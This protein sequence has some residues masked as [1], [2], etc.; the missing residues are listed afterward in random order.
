MAEEINFSDL[1]RFGFEVIVDESDAGGEFRIWR[2]QQKTHSDA[3][4]FW[5]DPLL[6]KRQAELVR[7]LLWPDRHAKPAGT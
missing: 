3:T 2:D 5:T 1:M 6:D 4:Q 7:W